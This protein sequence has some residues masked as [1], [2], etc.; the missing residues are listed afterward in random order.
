MQ[1][2]TILVGK[3]DD[4]PQI[5]TTSHGERL[6]FRL[7]R[8]AHGRVEEYTIIAWRALAQ[9]LVSLIS[10][11]HEVFVVGSQSLFVWRDGN[12]ATHT[13]VQVTADIVRMLP[14][15]AEHFGRGFGSAYGE[16]I[17]DEADGS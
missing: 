14:D 12:G 2:T 4:V 9:Q 5:R 15:V 17:I 7:R 10:S 13:R 8:E 1:T 16:E 11:G 6:Q 3:V